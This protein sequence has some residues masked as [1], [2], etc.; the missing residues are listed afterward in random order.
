VLENITAC[1]S[2][3]VKKLNGLLVALLYSIL[4]PKSVL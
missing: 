1:F 3:A 2:V 4:F